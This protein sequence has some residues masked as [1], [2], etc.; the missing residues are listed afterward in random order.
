[1]A[2]PFSGL[3]NIVATGGQPVAVANAGT[4]G[5]YVTNP[6]SAVD[7]NVPNAEPLYVDPVGP[8][9]ALAAGGTILALQPGDTYTLVPG[10]T[11][12]TIVNATTGGHKFTVVL[13]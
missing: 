1:M 11:L 12:P 13:W 2:T 6:L 10:S 8:C 3:S 5:G 4:N 9:V 7:Q